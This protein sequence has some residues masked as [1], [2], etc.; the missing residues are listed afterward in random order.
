[1]SDMVKVRDPEWLAKAY[2]PGPN[3][4]PLDSH[5]F[6]T[7][8]NILLGEDSVTA[9]N[10]T[11]GYRFYEGYVNGYVSYPGMVARHPGSTV[12]S[13]TVRPG[14]YGVDMIDVEPGCCTISE[15]VSFM[16]NSTH[17]HSTKPILYCSS[18]ESQIN[19][20]Y[21][22]A[23]GI[24]RSRYWLCG[25]HYGRGLHMCAPGTCGYASDDITQYATNS[26]VDSDAAYSYVF[27]PAPSP[28]PTNY[29]IQSGATGPLVKAL[30]GGLN[31]WNAGRIGFGADLATDSDFGPAVKAATIKAQEYFY[32]HGVAGGVATQW[33]LDQLAFDLWPV[34]QGMQG[35]DVE[36]L[37][38][39]LNRWRAALNFGAALATD[40][41][42]GSVTAHAVAVAQAH[43]GERGV[44]AG[45]CSQNVYDKLEG[46]PS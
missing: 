7:A 44:T 41:G 20:N 23:H 29:P 34:K 5:V 46:N 16:N 21:L 35:V 25:A 12:W 31:K 39:N 3:T 40:G 19:I 27:G 26:R 22:A 2:L 38:A 10:T 28:V 42:F 8:T 45:Q 30:Q 15:A 4:P 24:A 1:M 11:G 18:W 37:Q 36:H 17:P 9:G 43:F 33:L 32:Q 13:I 14:V 6:Y